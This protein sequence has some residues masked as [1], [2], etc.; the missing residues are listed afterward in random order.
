MLAVYRD[1]RKAARD[2]ILDLTDSYM[3]PQEGW[4]IMDR[5]EK[6]RPDFSKTEIKCEAFPIGLPGFVYIGR[7]Q[8]RFPFL[9]HKTKGET[10]GVKTAAVYLRDETSDPELHDWNFGVM[11]HSEY[12][13]SST[14]VGYGGRPDGLERVK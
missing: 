14:W 13:E 10:I 2:R 1:F 12:A 6:E 8:V 11:I 3:P 7:E 9:A 5:Y 4:A